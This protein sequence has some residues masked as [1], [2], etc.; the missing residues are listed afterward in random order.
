VGGVVVVFVGAVAF[1]GAFGWTLK[2]KAPWSGS[3]SRAETVIQRT[4]LFTLECST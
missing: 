1:A 3:P 4:I 2:K